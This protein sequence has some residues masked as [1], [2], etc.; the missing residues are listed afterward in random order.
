MTDWRSYDHIARRYDDVW[1]S[2]FEAVARHIW[3]LIPP[4]AGAIVL[5]IGT[6]TG[7]VPRSLGA[8]VGQLAGVIGCDR[9]AGMLSLARAMMPELRVLAAEATA[10][11]FG[12]SIFDVVTAS[13]VLSHL[14]NYRGGLVEAYRVLKPS[15][16]FVMASWTANTDPYSQAWSELLAEAVSK[17]RLQ[18]A[19][20]QVA[21]SEGYFE[22]VENVKTALAEAGFDCVEVHTIALECSFSLELYLAD[23]ELSSGGRFGQDALG[24]DRWGRFV[25]NAREKLRRSFGSH[26]KY[27]RG[28]LIGLGHRA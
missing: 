24:P 6:G 13:F 7:I 8:R 2:R 4:P 20:A 26:F 17:D 11:P 10:L 27:S 9:S 21:P 28:V 5:D 18:E 16:I 19:V 12:R 1:G 15:G 23:R 3:A 22:N 14:L 25:A